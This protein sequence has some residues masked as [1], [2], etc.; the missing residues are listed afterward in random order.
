MWRK[1]TNFMKGS[2]KNM[3]NVVKV[4]Q[5]EMDPKTIKASAE[6]VAGDLGLSFF[7]SDLTNRKSTNLL[8]KSPTY[9]FYHCS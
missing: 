9:S 2:L 4:L 5:P 3:I 1:T 6:L 7:F 8:Y